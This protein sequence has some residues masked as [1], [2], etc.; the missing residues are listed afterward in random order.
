MKM[1]SSKRYL[2]IGVFSLL[3]LG[4][5]FLTVSNAD[6]PSAGTADD[7]VITKSYF[8]QNVQAQVESELVKQSLTE[9]Q[10]KQLINE[11]LQGQ[12]VN[13]QGSGLSNGLT[14]GNSALTVI[15]LEA[16][17]T[18]YAG[19]GT[20]FIVRTGK[21]VAVSNDE[22]GIPDVTGGKDIAAG[23]EIATNHLLIFPS[24]GRGIKPAS[25]NTQDIYVMVR[26]SY[27][28]LNADGSTATP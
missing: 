19:A 12:A 26:G 8:E 7:P 27:L 28:L 22:N 20:E 4:T 16:G 24:D 14:A 3:L 15:Q 17:Q 13:T 6:A 10:V 11:A 23:S 25:K 18:L 21:T 9:N 2:T 1:K 5:Q